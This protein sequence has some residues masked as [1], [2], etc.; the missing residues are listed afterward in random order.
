[1]DTVKNLDLTKLIEA[2]EVEKVKE[3]AI[4]AARASSGK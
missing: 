4:E 2:G 1:M 3:S